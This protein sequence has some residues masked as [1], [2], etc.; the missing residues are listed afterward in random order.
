[1]NFITVIKLI[2]LSLAFPLYKSLFEFEKLLYRNIL[3]PA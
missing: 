3:D 1:M 2:P